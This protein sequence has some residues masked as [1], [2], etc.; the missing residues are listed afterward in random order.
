M[1]EKGNIP[2]EVLR[3]DDRC[4][5]RVS[6]CVEFNGLMSLEVLLSKEYVKV[7]VFLD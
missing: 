1:A 5:D 7:G 2:D 4:G 3:G 6:K